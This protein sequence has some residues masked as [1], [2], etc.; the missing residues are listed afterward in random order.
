MVFCEVKDLSI[1]IPA[2]REMFLKNTIDDILAN[3]E[4]DTEVIAVLDGEWADPPI[5]DNPRVHIVYHAKPIGQRAAVNEAARISTAKYIMKVDAHCAFDKGFDVKLM[6]DYEEGQTVIPRMYNL[7]AFDWVCECGERV[8]QGARASHCGKEMEMDLV[9][10]PRLHRRSDYARFDRQ[11]HFQYWYKYSNDT[12]EVMCFVG[13]AFLMS[14]EQFWK[15]DG[16]DE[17]HGGWG[18]MGV[19]VSCKTWLSGGRLVVNKNTWFAHLF[20]TQE[21]F[22]FPYPISFD[23]QERAREYSKWLW[24]LEQPDELPRWDKAVRPLKWLVDKFAPV[25]E[26]GN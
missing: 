9:W 11:L 22:K 3:I 2:R 7:H 6:R 24:N 16:L 25:P 23:E 8:Y 12:N 21:G 19:E 14:R 15:L 17:A 18:Q 1:L 5:P 10:K 26:W 4:A 20:R 13:A